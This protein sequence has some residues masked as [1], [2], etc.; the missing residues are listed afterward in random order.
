MALIMGSLSDRPVLQAAADEL[1]RFSVAYLWRVVSAHRNPAQMLDFAATAQ[2]KGLKVIIAAA[3][4]AAHLPG[5]VAAATTLPVIGV[6]VLSAHSLQ[7]WDSLLSVLQMPAGVPVATMAVDGA[8]NAALFA[9][10]IL[11]LSD[12][13]LVTQLRTHKQA[14]IDRVEQQNHTLSQGQE[15]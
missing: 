7:G 11:G 3:G 14:L 8:Q 4:G 6:P 15:E 2:G 5:M 12:P 1:D 9:V 10:Q 13:Q